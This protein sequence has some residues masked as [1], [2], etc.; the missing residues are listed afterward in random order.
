MEQI[1]ARLLQD[2]E[3]GKMNRRQLI[4]SLAVAAAAAAAA[5]PVTAQARGFKA[6]TVN[7]ISYQV[8]DYT[9]TRDFYVDLLG[10]KVSGDN[11]RQCNLSF[12][13]TFLLPRNA[14]NGGATPRVDHIAYTIEAWDQQA[15]KS[16]LERRGLA[17]R[18]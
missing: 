11:G 18:E 12:G 13:D 14:R 5:T 2:F 1:I 16:E 8:A 15:V 10:M 7:H 3:Q 4:R 17:P 6:L 9:K